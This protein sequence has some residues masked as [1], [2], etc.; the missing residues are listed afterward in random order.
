M[1]I[2]IWAFISITIVE[3]LCGIVIG[4]ELR[5]TVERYL[6]KRKE[7]NGNSSSG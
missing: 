5:I 2:P 4:Y 3:V 1:T 6:A 7:H